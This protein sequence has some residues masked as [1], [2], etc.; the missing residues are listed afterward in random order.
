MKA[1]STT[2]LNFRAVQ[3]ACLQWRNQHG[4]LRVSALPVT[5]Y[6]V[7]GEVFINDVGDLKDYAA[8][9]PDYPNETMYERAKR[10]DILDVWTPQARFKLSANN[11]LLYRGEEALKIYEA[12]RGWYYNSIR[13]KTDKE[14]TG[15]KKGRKKYEQQALRP[16]I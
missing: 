11:E 16:L 1:T 6:S 5:V 8:Y 9:H 2:I 15:K 12:Y 10:L 13:K 3:H 7:Y 4:N 14:F